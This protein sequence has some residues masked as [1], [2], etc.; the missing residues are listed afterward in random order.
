M[1]VAVV[2]LITIIILLHCDVRQKRKGN[3]EPSFSE[4][5]FSRRLFMPLTSIIMIFSLLVMPLSR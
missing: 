5:R 2:V 4:F 3:S 1:L